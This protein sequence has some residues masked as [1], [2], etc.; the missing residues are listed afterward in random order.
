MSRVYPLLSSLVVI[1]ALVAA[2]GQLAGSARGSKAHCMGTASHTAGD[3]D[4]GR[5]G[6]GQAEG[7]LPTLAVRLAASDLA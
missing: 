6:S 4:K 2:C 1:A 3:A 7:P 5:E